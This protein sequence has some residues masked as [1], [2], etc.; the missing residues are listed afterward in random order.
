MHR[1]TTQ[2]LP[3]LST[4]RSQKKAIYTQVQKFHTSLPALETEGYKQ[5]LKFPPSLPFC[6]SETSSKDWLHMFAEVGGLKSKQIWAFLI[7]SQ[8][9]LGNWWPNFNLSLIWNSSAITTQSLQNFKLGGSKECQDFKLQ[10]ITSCQGRSKRR[11]GYAR[12][13]KKECAKLGVIREQK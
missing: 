5:A 12:G 1:C 9:V 4:L 2:K 3:C 8:T 6:T 7:F 10:C 13:K 11:E